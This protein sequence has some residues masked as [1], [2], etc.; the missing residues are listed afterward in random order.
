M[1]GSMQT[2]CQGGKACWCACAYPVMHVG[3]HVLLLCCVCSPGAQ[4][5]YVTR[6]RPTA[7]SGTPVAWEERMNSV[8]STASYLHQLVAEYSPSTAAFGGPAALLHSAPGRRSTRDVA[9]M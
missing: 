7:W 3:V 8:C 6:Q 1:I 5:E 2:Y 4:L 9:G